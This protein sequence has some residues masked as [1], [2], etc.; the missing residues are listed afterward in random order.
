MTMDSAAPQA[1]R[2]PFLIPLLVVAVLLG[3]F[4]KRLIDVS[5][6]D[7]PHLVPSVLLNTPLPEFNL[8][9]LPDREQGLATA[10]LRGQVSLLNIWGSWCVACLAEHPFLMQLKQRDAIPIHG[11]AWRDTP[12]ASSQWLAKHGDPYSRIGQDP[13]SVAAIALGVTGAPETFVID[14]SGMIRY[15][16]VGPI[17][18]EVWQR[19]LAPL[20]AQLQQ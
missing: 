6:G 2:W 8:P 16:H 4:G 3:I 13:R 20:I 14:A 1:K 7:D 17:T 10:D 9:A 19:T 12:T 11:I 18:P 5:G 15:K